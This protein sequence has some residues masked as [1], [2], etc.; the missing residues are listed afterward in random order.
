VESHGFDHGFPLIRSLRGSA[1]RSTSVLFSFVAF[2]HC[3]RIIHRPTIKN[4]LRTPLELGK[5]Q[6]QKVA[7]PESR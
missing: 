5:R 7:E 4:E 2:F 6:Q 3:G 1:Q